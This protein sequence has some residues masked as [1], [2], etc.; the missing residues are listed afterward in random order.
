MF[1]YILRTDS[2]S[3]DKGD[4]FFERFLET[5][6]LLHVFD[7][8]GVDNPDDELVVA[9]WEDRKAAEDYLN[10]SP[11]RQEIDQTFSGV[12][13]TMSEVLNGK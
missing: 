4:E 13:R 1:A 9:I 8:R 2:R 7:L 10:N 3:D 11:L 5:P 6:G 12:T